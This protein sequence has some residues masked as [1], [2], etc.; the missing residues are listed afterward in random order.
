MVS[1]FLFSLAAFINQL[2]LYDVDRPGRRARNVSRRFQ[3][4]SVLNWQS[5]IY[6]TTTTTTTNFRCSTDKILSSSLSI[7]IDAFEF[8][9]RCLIGQ[10]D[11]TDLT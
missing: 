1:R 6:A 4:E 8:F 10:T 9:R 3:I 2:A 11:K 7:H 5:S